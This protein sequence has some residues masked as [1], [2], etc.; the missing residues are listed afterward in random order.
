MPVR[1]VA[2]VTEIAEGVVA[3][4]AI[5]QKFDLREPER[6]RCVRLLVG[7]VKDSALWAKAHARTWE[8]S[9]GTPYGPGG[10]MRRC[11]SGTISMRHEARGQ[12][13]GAGGWGRLLGP[14]GRWLGLAPGPA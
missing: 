13:A 7:A 5:Y 8:H 11:S 10:G 2:L 1:V 14:G 4:V 12:V 9:A 3:I 6:T